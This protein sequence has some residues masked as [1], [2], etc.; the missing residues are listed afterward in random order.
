VEG[1]SGWLVAGYDSL[2]IVPDDSTTSSRLAPLS[3]VQTSDGKSQSVFKADEP[4]PDVSYL[5]KSQRL[6]VATR[7]WEGERVRP[8]GKVVIADLASNRLDKV[9]KV[10]RK[11]AKFWSAMGEIGLG[12]ALAAASG[13]C[14]AISCAPE[15]TSQSSRRSPPA[16]CPNCSALTASAGWIIEVRLDALK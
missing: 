4:T 9:V 11:G 13:A 10:G 3:H 7:R 16:V 2:L 15:I 12:M 6:F 14:T 8:A 1:L 5:P